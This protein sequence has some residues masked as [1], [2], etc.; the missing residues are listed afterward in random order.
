MPLS[1]AMSSSA[2]KHLEII[3][4]VHHA[5]DRLKEKFPASVPFKDLVKFVSFARN[6]EVPSKY[7]QDVKYFKRIL[8]LRTDVSSDEASDTFKFKPPYNISSPEQLVGWFQRQDQFR[9]IEVR[10]LKQGWP[11]CETAIDRLEKEHKLIVLRNKKDNNPRTLWPDDP[12]LNVP[13]DAEFVDIWNRVLLPERDEVIKS[14]QKGGHI[15][16]G[17]VS[18]MVVKQ[19]AEKKKRKARINTKQTNNHMSGIFKDYSGQRP[20]GK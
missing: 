11:E 14:L 1:V 17:E 5:V 12:D 10:D 19:A 20:K 7:D 9:S 2:A 16:T 6:D 13:L 18:K 3:P 8:R 15:P 4:K